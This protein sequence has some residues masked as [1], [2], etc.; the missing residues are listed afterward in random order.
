MNNHGTRFNRLETRQD[1]Y[2]DLNEP[3]GVGFNGNHRESFLIFDV[4]RGGCITELSKA[5]IT[6]TITGQ[7]SRSIGEA[8]IHVFSAPTTWSETLVTANNKPAASNLITVIP[9]TSIVSNFTTVTINV[10]AQAKAALA[11]GENSIGITLQSVT[12]SPPPTAGNAPPY[13]L[14]NLGS[15][16][17][18]N[19]TYRPFIRLTL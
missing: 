15:K 12:I 14:I 17:H 19:A 7:S 5:E 13:Q 6:L 18:A 9:T 11:A 10:T 1:S 8:D 16:E 2:I 4:S 3:G